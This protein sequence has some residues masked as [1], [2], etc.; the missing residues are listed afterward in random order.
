[1]RRR[2]RSIRLK[3][4]PNVS[5]LQQ[6]RK[7]GGAGEPLCASCGGQQKRKRY[8]NLQRTR[9]CCME[10][11]QPE[12]GACMHIYRHAYACTPTTNIIPGFRVASHTPH[13]LGPAT[14]AHEVG[15]TGRTR[16]M[17]SRSSAGVLLPC[18]P[19]GV[20]AQWQ[21]H[22]AAVGSVGTTCGSRGQVPAS[23]V[24]LARRHARTRAGTAVVP[25]RTT[26][27]L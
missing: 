13:T 16:G 14:H 18:Q 19:Q 4:S 17:R 9:L 11:I 3:T 21:G 23:T 2:R 7:T 27:T 6:G 1:M 22:E 24:F 8:R 12:T 15:A 5:F 10:L 25:G 26:D 20:P